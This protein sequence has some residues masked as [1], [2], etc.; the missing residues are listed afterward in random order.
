M[1]LTAIECA[2]RCVDRDSMFNTTASVCRMQCSNPGL[3]QTQVML[4]AAV[5]D[6]AFGLMVLTTLLVGLC[7]LSL[8]RKR[9]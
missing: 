7:G 3:S 6:P 5:A 4:T 2:V 1:L 9:K 8:W